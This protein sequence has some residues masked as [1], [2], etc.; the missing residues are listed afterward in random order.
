MCSARRLRRPV[1]PQ[2]CSPSATRARRSSLDPGPQIPDPTTVDDAVLEAITA[3]DADI[4]CVALGNPK[5]ER[6][7]KAH[8][9]RLGVPVMIGVGGSLD[10]LVGERRRAPR[11]MQRTGTEWIAR[12]AQEP[13]PARRPLCPRRSGLRPPVGSGVA[14]GS[15]PTG[16][17]RN[18]RRGH[19]PYRRRA[20][21]R[22]DR[23]WSRCVEP[24]SGRPRRGCWPATVVWLGDVYRRP[25]AR[26]AHRPRAA[27][28]ASQ[29]R[30]ALARRPV[31]VD[32]GAVGSRHP[33]RAH[34][35]IVNNVRF[36]PKLVP[37]KPVRPAQSGAVLAPDLARR[38]PPA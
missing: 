25:C 18:P 13:A 28:T 6:F 35:G 19:G 20:D 1:A 12:L 30:G 11:W 8:R 5:Q 16:S 10:L 2:T 27:G 15:G 7:I 26:R 9:E 17:G 24:S 29:C 38:R 22:S 36:E 37:C 34:R 32:R 4:L 23:A 14:G 21:R 31:A 3:V 33:A